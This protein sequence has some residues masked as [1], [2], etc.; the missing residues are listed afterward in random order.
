MTAEELVNIAVLGAL[1]RWRSILVVLI[2]LTGVALM[3][4]G[5]DAGARLL[6]VWVV[7]TTGLA[8]V[9]VAA[10]DFSKNLI[11][12]RADP[13]ARG[14]GAR[15]ASV[16][17]ALMLAALA[18]PP[19]VAA[20][21]NTLNV[22]G[23]AALV[24]TP[25]LAEDLNSQIQNHSLTANTAGNIANRE[26]FGWVSRS[27]GTAVLQTNIDG[28]AWVWFLIV[29]SSIL[30]L[31]RALTQSYDAM[32]PPKDGG[33]LRPPLMNYPKWLALC[34]YAAILVP[35]T[36]FSLG[37][38]LRL[39]LDSKGTEISAVQTQ[40]KE[41]GAAAMD[42]APGSAVNLDKIAT[43][44]QVS[45]YAFEHPSNRSVK[46]TTT[47][48]LPADYIPRLVSVQNAVTDARGAT[49]RLEAWRAEYEALALQ[50]ATAFKRFATADQ[51]ADHAAAVAADYRAKI[52]RF[53]AT[54]RPCL[55]GLSDIEAGFG[56]QSPVALEPNLAGLVT[57]RCRQS[58]EALGPDK[59][60]KPPSPVLCNKTCPLSSP[61]ASAAQ[62]VDAPSVNAEQATAAGREDKPIA[63]CFACRGR[64]NDVL[65][66]WMTDISDSAVLIVGLVGFGLF[67]AAIRMLGRPDQATVTEAD[68]AAAKLKKKAARG[69]L[70]QKIKARI[71]AQQALT[72]AQAAEQPLEALTKALE[73]AK[74]EEQE[75]TTLASVADKEVAALERRALD[76]RSNF[77]VDRTSY[78]A[79]GEEV[80][81]YVVSGAP[82]KVLV[83]GLG[84][85]FTV[86]LAG[87]AGVKIF[88]EGGQTS[89]TGLLLACFIGAVFAENIWASVSKSISE[90]APTPQKPS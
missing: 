73:Q 35:A 66:G 50:Q 9:A 79:A 1:R 87:K 57:D 30:F 56:D 4:F 2:G 26:I 74:E 76:D 43:R 80:H 84:A 10:F 81:E 62:A 53:R 20:T 34:L 69:A 85:A 45:R 78:N 54:I 27:I 52:L 90:R 41:A 6:G 25:Q 58:S 36:Y 23:Y 16:V 83:S 46:R 49:T 61:T 21:A 8:V 29:F 77:V 19:V 89:P 65:Y 88:T 48:P 11:G 7:L 39:G 37:A 38:L 44:L 40:L 14:L 64:V 75:A 71:A 22:L 63:D 86:F 51:F 28:A 55:I 13:G 72:N 12:R 17:L 3:F 24:I 47:P 70:D 5:W 82:A 42:A 68:F 67:G 18:S 33:P 31:T 59:L 32:S 60:P 15:S